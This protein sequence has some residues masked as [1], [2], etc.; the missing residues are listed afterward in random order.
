MA[1]RFIFNCILH[2]GGDT[3]ALL[4]SAAYLEFYSRSEVF[5][6]WR[7]IFS[8][9]QNTACGSLSTFPGSDGYWFDGQMFHGKSTITDLT[10]R[11]EE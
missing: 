8:P 11:P 1:R 6:C 4:I 3:T 10:L 2:S 9:K 5:G 7:P